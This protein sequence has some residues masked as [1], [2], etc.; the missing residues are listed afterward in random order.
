[1]GF[2]QNRPVVTT[3]DINLQNTEKNLNENYN[4]NHLFSQNSN[5]KIQTRN[6]INQFE[7]E[8]IDDDS[9][10]I[11]DG[12]VLKNLGVG[13]NNNYSNLNERRDNGM[14]VK[15]KAEL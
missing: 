11:L 14:N 9:N 10:N 4:Q 15:N 2:Q 12:D 8:K 7:D 13:D 3:K 1:M 5:A 6:L